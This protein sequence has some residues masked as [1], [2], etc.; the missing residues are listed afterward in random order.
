VPAVSED[1]EKAVIA[2]ARAFVGSE[3]HGFSPIFDADPFA[4]DL[5][6]AVQELE[7]AL[8]REQIKDLDIAEKPTETEVRAD[9]LAEGDEIFSVATGKWHA[10][11]AASSH[12]GRTT[13]V[14]QKDER[15]TFRFQPAPETPFTTRRGAAGRAADMF[16]AEEVRHSA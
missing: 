15:S 14:I 13:I 12:G 6:R 2:A 4:D 3:E 10:V 9:L 16:G 7:K 8:V 5:R 1:L 11:V